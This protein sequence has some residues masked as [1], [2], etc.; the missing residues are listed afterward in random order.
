MQDNFSQT[1]M[2]VNWDSAS[3]ETSSSFC[4]KGGKFENSCEKR[5]EWT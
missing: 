2:L 1:G 3:Y 5:F 4:S